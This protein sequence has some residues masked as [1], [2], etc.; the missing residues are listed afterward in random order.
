MQAE[1]KL[2]CTNQ[3][4][5]FV[6]SFSV[7]S[8][9]R[10]CQ[11]HQL[12]V[13]IALL[14]HVGQKQVTYRYAMPTRTAALKHSSSFPMSS[15]TKVGTEYN[16]SLFMY[17]TIVKRNIDAEL[18]NLSGIYL[19]LN[20]FKQRQHQLTLY[21]TLTDSNQMSICMCYL[22]CLCQKS[23]N[24]K[25]DYSACCRP[26]ITLSIKSCQSKHIKVKW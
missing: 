15:K 1:E 8:F 2:T 7:S 10:R 16:M 3:Y 11:V 12:F 13:V 4:S 9:A 21:S 14:M 22:T 18:V 19:H 6:I 25:Q 17:D 24:L 23:H 20:R 5:S 26:D